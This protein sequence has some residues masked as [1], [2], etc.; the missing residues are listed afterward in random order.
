M[1]T[2]LGMMFMIM[3]FLISIT[4]FFS[5]SVVA[6]NCF[7]EAGLTYNISPL[8]L[9]AIAHQESNLKP[10]AINYNTNGSYD[11]GIMQINSSW[12]S[13]LGHDAWL[14]LSDP[15]YNIHVGA[16][17]LSGCINKYGYNWNAVGCYNSN[18]R[19][20]RNKYAKKIMRKINKLNISNK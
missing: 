20:K 3:T 13:V 19:D 9:Y 2:Y 6:G 15:C 14:H 7:E 8:L 17:I 12:Y 11:Y 16:W 5:G 4:F 10:N 18:Y 1:K